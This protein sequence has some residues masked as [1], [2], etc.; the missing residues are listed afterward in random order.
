MGKRSAP[1]HNSASPDRNGEFLGRMGCLGRSSA[2]VIVSSARS[3][4]RCGLSCISCHGGAAEG[5]ETTDER[6]P[7]ARYLWTTN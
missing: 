6:F 4:G 1:M 7:T 2:A 3:I 5:G